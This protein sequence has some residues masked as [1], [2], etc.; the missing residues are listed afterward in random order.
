MDYR[1]LPP[2]KTPSTGQA[3]FDRT[4]D[5]GRTFSLTGLFAG[6]ALTLATGAAR[7][8]EQAQVAACTG[9]ADV[10]RR[11]A[12]YDDLVRVPLPAAEP[13]LASV[14]LPRTRETLDYPTVDLLDLRVDRDQLIGRG[15]TTAGRLNVSGQL[16]FLR[17]QGIDNT[18]LFVSIARLPAETQREI[19]ARCGSAC[20]ATLRGKIVHV[21]LGIGLAAEDVSIR[22]ST[23]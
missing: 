5:P 13:N 2:R 7:A 20:S 16:G 15:V 18:P 23:P 9:T 12:C 3:Q 6:L 1:C 8:V 19:R 17:S 21:T 10:M 14:A 22:P 11:L 4:C